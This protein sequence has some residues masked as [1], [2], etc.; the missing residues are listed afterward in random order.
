MECHKVVYL[1]RYYFLF[2]FFNDLHN[3]GPGGKIFM[4]ADDICL[5]YPQKHETVVNAYMER[6]SALICKFP[7]INKLILNANKTQLIRFKPTYN[8]VNISIIF[9]R[10]KATEGNSL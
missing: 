3:L 10:K 5:V 6:D 9:D 4:Y 1:G 2:F 8:N 7:R